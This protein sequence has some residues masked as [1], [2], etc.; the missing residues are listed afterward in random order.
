MLR[1]LKFVQGAISRK[2]LVPAMTHF[3][4]EKGFVRAYN[5]SLG[6]CA[7]IAFDI[8][9]KPKAGPLVQ[10]IAQSSDT[11]QLSMTSTG[12]LRV[13]SGE[14]KAYV[15]CVPLDELTPH[16]QPEGEHVEFN[17]DAMLQAL[18]AVEPFIGTDASRPWSTG[19]LMRGESVYATNNVT[20]VEYWTGARLPIE[21]NVPRSAVMEML[22]INEA[23]THAQVTETSIT[24]HYSDQRWVRTQLLDV[25]WPADMASLF[26]G[27]NAAPIDPRLFEALEKLAPF[28]DKS[29]RVYMDEGIL[30]TVSSNDVDEG[31]RFELPSFQHT[32]IYNVEMLLMLKDRATHADFSLYPKPCIFYGDRLRGAIIGIRM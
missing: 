19:V 7:P 15:D 8:D 28:T 9:C 2:E 17:G 20:G 5:G 26:K 11:I 21:I 16:V 12:R 27:D 4:I 18:K 22:R 24:F 31:A 1:E 29:G 23:P 25:K 13:S 3:A 10:A 6:L 14:F 30:R 32:G